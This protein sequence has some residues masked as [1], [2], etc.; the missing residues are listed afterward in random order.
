MSEAR[1]TRALALLERLQRDE[2][3]SRAVQLAELTARRARVDRARADVLAQVEQNATSP[4]EIG[5]S[6][7]SNWIRSACSEADRLSRES[8]RI[9]AEIAAQKDR[10]LDAYRDA[11]KLRFVIARRDE[12]RAAKEAAAERA[13]LEPFLNLAPGPRK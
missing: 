11:E 10:V 12:V 13:A 6:Y 1:R 8:T 3:Q 7:L 4:D 5:A 2:A 9:G